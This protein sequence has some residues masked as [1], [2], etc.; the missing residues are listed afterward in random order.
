MNHLDKARAWYDAQLSRLKHIQEL[1]EEH[2]QETH[3]RALLGDLLRLRKGERKVRLQQEREDLYR[4]ALMRL[5]AGFEAD[6]KD[7]FFEYIANRSGM[8]KKQ[9][10]ETLPDAISTWLVMYRV[11]EPQSFSESL[12]GQI[13]RI[14]D[15]RNRLAHGGFHQ[16]FAHTTPDEAYGALRQPLKTLAAKAQG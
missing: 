11:L 14:R 12:M 8:S 2:D 13:N 10:T 4:V 16:E 1:S 6:F 5:F 9:V 3:L 7:G 15:E